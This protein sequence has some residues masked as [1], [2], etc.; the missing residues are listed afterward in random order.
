[1]LKCGRPERSFPV[2]GGLLAG[3]VGQLSETQ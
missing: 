2:L 3:D 1:M